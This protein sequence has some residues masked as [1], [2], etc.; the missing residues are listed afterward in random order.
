MLLLLLQV[1]LAQAPVTNSCDVVRKGNISDGYFRCVGL[2]FEVRFPGETK[3]ENAPNIYASHG[4]WAKFAG[5]ETNGAMVVHQRHAWERGDTVD[6]ALHSLVTD[7]M[8]ALADPPPFSSR[9]K[10]PTVKSA[11]LAQVA[12]KSIAVPSGP[13]MTAL[14]ATLTQA[15]AKLVEVKSVSDGLKLLRAGTVQYF[16]G[17]DLALVELMDYATESLTGPPMGASPIAM[18]VPKGS[19]PRYEPAMKKLAPELEA[20]RRK[21]RPG[22]A[23]DEIGFTACEKGPVERWTTL[24]TKTLTFNDEK[25]PARSGENHEFYEGHKVCL[26]ELSRSDSPPPKAILAQ[27][28]KLLA[29]QEAKVLK[30]SEELGESDFRPALFNAETEELEYWRRVPGAKLAIVPW[31]L[32]QRCAV[33]EDFWDCSEQ[34]F[35]IFAVQGTKVSMTTLTTRERMENPY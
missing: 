26:T 1:A 7:G 18:A 19:L 12:D 15:K 9:D 33:D 17:E 11:D 27:V 13:T 8:K 20:L 2:P 29:A 23:V 34:G 22:S 4:F 5:S 21:Y 35:F 10:P 28:R 3:V 25:V 16:A 32:D 6:D 31:E 24:A 30:R 14:G